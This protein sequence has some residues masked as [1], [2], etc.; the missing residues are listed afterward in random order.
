MKYQTANRILPEELI[1]EIQKY[2]DGELI[3]IPVKQES[4]KEWG[5]LSG[6]R[7]KLKERNRQMKTDF[8]QGATI[9][10]LAERY[11]LSEHTIKNIVYR[12]KKA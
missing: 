10:E 11:Y 12:K 1:A 6:A 5:A 4:K 7:Q 9:T 3:Y 2:I 8:E